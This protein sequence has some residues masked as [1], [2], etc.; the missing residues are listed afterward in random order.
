MHVDKQLMDVSILCELQLTHLWGMREY[1][2]ELKEYLLEMK[3]LA[4]YYQEL[5]KAVDAE[6]KLHYINENIKLVESVMSVKELDIFD[7]TEFG[8]ICLN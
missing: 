1:L 5:K 3:D 4:I 6:T 7:V 8:E 2:V